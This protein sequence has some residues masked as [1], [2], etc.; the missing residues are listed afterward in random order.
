MT[1]TLK[2]RVETFFNLLDTTYWMKSKKYRSFIDHES[3]DDGKESYTFSYM[4]GEEEMLVE[5][6]KTS[7]MDGDTENYISPTYN[8]EI[9]FTMPERSFYIGNEHVKTMQSLNRIFSGLLKTWSAQL[10]QQ[11]NG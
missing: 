6:F 11:K 4:V 2:P 1:T 3:G 8:F 7:N 10:K 5:A 9:K